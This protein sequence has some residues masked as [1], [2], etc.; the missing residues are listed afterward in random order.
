MLVLLLSVVKILI[1][2]ICMSTAEHRA[3]IQKEVVRGLITLARPVGKG[4]VSNF[5]IVIEML[6]WGGNLN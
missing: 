4:F 2:S 1:N 5:V 6:L 3:L